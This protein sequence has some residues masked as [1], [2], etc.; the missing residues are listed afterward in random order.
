M[1]TR[2]R[3]RATE[4]W[5]AQRQGLYLGKSPENMLKLIDQKGGDY[6][7]FD[8][9]PNQQVISDAESDFSIF[10]TGT[11]AMTQ[12]ADDMRRYYGLTP[13][14]PLPTSIPAPAPAPA[15]L[16]HPAPTNGPMQGPAQAFAAK[17]V[18]E[19]KQKMFGPEPPPARVE[20]DLMMQQ[21]VAAAEQQ[22][23]QLESIVTQAQEEL[24]PKGM[25]I[26]D[27]YLETAILAAGALA[28]GG[29]LGR[30]TAPQEEEQPIYL[31]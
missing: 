30:A 5:V 17:K 9:Y 22:Q 3:N 19:V 18:A 13:S 25:F 31:R 6:Y 28:T 2:N 20:E 8:L 27:P 1:R 24:K 21:Q 4:E 7:K 23:Q 10:K 26:D 16:S 12:I 11:P 15:V 29:V 14:A